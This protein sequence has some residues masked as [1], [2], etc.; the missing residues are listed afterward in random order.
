MNKFPAKM[1]YLSAY[2][3]SLFVEIGDM[4]IL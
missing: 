2:F 1:S 3:L 4:N